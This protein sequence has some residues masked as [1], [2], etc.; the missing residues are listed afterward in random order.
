MACYFV[1]LYATLLLRMYGSW[2]RGC[3]NLK[4]NEKGGSETQVKHIESGTGPERE[5]SIPILRQLHQPCKNP[6]F[7]YDHF[8][9]K[10]NTLQIG[11]WNRSHTHIFL[12]EPYSWN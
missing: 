6:S 9:E 2:V 5:D 1:L 12:C 8:V 3:L 4:G 11:A 7:T 10:F